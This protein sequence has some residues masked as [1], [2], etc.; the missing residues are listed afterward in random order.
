MLRRTEIMNL[1]HAEGW[2]GSSEIWKVD[3]DKVVA[4]TLL[5]QDETD[6]LSLLV[7]LRQYV[8][9]ELRMVHV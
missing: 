1:R 5:P 4:K 6:E 2:A 9:R 8:G 3:K 7:V